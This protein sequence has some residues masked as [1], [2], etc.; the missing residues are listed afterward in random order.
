MY[1][2]DRMWS[3]LAVI[4]LW[5]VYAFTFVTIVLPHA[6][7]NVVIALATAGGIVLLFNTAAIIA[8]LSHYSEDKDNIYGLDLHY[9]DM[10]KKK[11]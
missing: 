4:V 5:A 11:G 8:M 1:S 6:D 3:L 7:Q 10:M 9:L 2:G